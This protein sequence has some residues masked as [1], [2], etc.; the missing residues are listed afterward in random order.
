MFSSVARSSW[1]GR[2]GKG[3][4]CALVCSLVL[5]STHH[6]GED[7]G[8]PHAH[9]FLHVFCNLFLLNSCCCLAQPCT[10]CRGPG[11]WVRGF[12]FG[13][14]RSFDYHFFRRSF[15]YFFSWWPGP[16][17]RAVG[18]GEMFLCRRIFMS[19]FHSYTHWDETRGGRG[20]G[21]KD[22]LHAS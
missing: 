7:A 20:F 18:Q 11:G 15:G 17:G 6:V 12:V 1:V 9:L 5:Q 2:V 14:R 3:T 22:H 19:L 10:V 8:Y 16:I 4:F 13:R 21:F